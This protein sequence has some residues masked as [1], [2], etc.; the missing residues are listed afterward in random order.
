[1]DHPE[2]P[3]K[4]FAS[5]LW[6]NTKSILYNTWSLLIEPFKSQSA[7]WGTLGG[8]IIVGIIGTCLDLLII[9]IKSLTDYFTRK[10]LDPEKYQATLEKLEQLED[11]DIES[12]AQQIKD[13]YTTPESKSSQALSRLLQQSEPDSVV[14]ESF[15][16]TRKE[17]L[18][19]VKKADK[20]RTAAQ[21]LSF[22]EGVRVVISLTKPEEKEIK[23]Q[24]ES[25][26]PGKKAEELG[27]LKQQ[28]REQLISFFTAP[29]NAGKR[30]QHV[31]A[32]ITESMSVK[33]K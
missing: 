23:A 26:I 11:D 12:L 28:K 8:G 19:R 22:E 33:A 17:E 30:M 15:A 21:I 7:N 13:S 5:I 27:K 14:I 29:H 6:R 4:S 1:M 16:N 32:D 2:M 18:A 3:K 20:E 10:E 31:I 24:V 9:P 25:E